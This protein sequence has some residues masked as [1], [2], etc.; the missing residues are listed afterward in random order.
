MRLLLIFQ[1]LTI[2][3]WASLAG[4]RHAEVISALR[5]LESVQVRERGDYE[6]GE[7]PT[8]VT[9]T[10]TPSLIGVGV[11]GKEYPEATLFT[12]T[13]IMNLLGSMY[14]K[15]PRLP[16]IPQMMEKATRA[17]PAYQQGPLFNFYPPRERKGVWVRGPRSLPL[18]PYVRGLANI[19]P[20]SDSTSVTYAALN[21]LELMRDQ[22]TSGDFIISLPPEV[23]EAFAEFRDLDREPHYYDKRMGLVN[24]G[25]YMTW[26]LDEKDPDMPRRWG[27][28]EKG[29]RIPF[30]DNDVDCV[31][32]ANVLKLLTWAGQTE[33]PGYQA[34]CKLLKRSIDENL[35]SK[36][37]VYYPNSFALPLGVAELH[38]LGASC[39]TTHSQKVLRHVLSLQ[40]S[41]GFW[42]NASPHRVDYIQSTV[43][44]L[45][46]LVLLG[47]PKNSVHRQRVQKGVEYLMKQSRRDKNGNLYWPG[48]VFFSAVAQARYTVVWRSNAYTTALA[49]RALLYAQDFEKR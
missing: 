35:Y 21:H 15:D 2:L 24:T 11:W 28:P 25:A 5:Y 43:L 34:S 44:A 16:L 26:L 39:L 46:A 20:D 32:N 19:P 6:P 10:Y 13:T 47:D 49:A 22:N 29:V 31:I 30:G 37:G 17:F 3:P 23:P 9:S 7:W 14:Q 4:D 42:G 45:N 48:Q 8:G 18:A 36:C 33:T 12:T 1:I 40:R 41:D 38:Q 27:R